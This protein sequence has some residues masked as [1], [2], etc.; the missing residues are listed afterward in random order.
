MEKM[1]SVGMSF[2]FGGTVLGI[3]AAFDRRRVAVIAA[4]TARRW[5]L[6]DGPLAAAV[7]LE[8]VATKLQKKIQS[9][10]SILRPIQTRTCT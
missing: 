2:G 4:A 9:I 8:S 7:E 1:A 5:G 10:R 3:T 6:D